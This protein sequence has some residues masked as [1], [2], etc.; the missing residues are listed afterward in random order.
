MA[1]QNYQLLKSNND[2][3]EET[4]SLE[5]FTYFFINFDPDLTQTQI[6]TLKLTPKLTQVLILK[7][8]PK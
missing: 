3:S 8:A 7:K 4:L 5:I 6:L 2:S 1:L